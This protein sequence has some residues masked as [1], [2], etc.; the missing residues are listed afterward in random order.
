M[1]YV[2]RVFFGDSSMLVQ[3]EEP[4][5]PQKIY[6]YMNDFMT[7]HNKN[8]DP[9]FIRASSIV[10]IMQIECYSEDTYPVS[11]DDLTGADM[12]FKI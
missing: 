12:A 4:I 10:G 2:T 8:G 11:F 6:S 1:T 3:T 5:T 9:V 7:F